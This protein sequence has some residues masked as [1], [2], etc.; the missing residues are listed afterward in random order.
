MTVRR[1]RDA[2]CAARAREKDDMFLPFTILGGLCFRAGLKGRNIRY[3]REEKEG[4][5]RYRANI[6]SQKVKG[7]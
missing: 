7:S 2:N 4:P 1:K 6:G 5:R 3:V